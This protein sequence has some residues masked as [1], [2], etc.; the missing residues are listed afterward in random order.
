MASVE[1]GSEL[2]RLALQAIDL[3]QYSF[4]VRRRRISGRRFS[5][6][7]VRKRRPEIRLRFAGYTQQGCC[8]RNSWMSLTVSSKRH[9][10][11]C[12]R[13]QLTKM[14]Q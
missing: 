1:R 5:P 14:R 7:K 3:A 8:R 2:G 13:L 12:R 9:R 4:S 10:E 11:N 6:S